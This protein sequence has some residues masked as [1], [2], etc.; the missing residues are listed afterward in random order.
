MKIADGVTVT[1]GS[2][3]RQ[4]Q[5]GVTVSFERASGGLSHPTHVDLE[6]LEVVVDPSSTDQHLL[7]TVNVPHGAISGG[8][9]LSIESAGGTINQADVIDVTPI[10]AGPSGDDSNLGTTNE[11]FRTLKQALS[12]AGPNDTCVLSAGTYDVTSG[13]TWGYTP[14]DALTLTGDSASGT[15][16]QGPAAASLTPAG[17]LTVQNLSFSGFGSALAITETAQ[18]SVNDVTID[19]GGE[20]IVLGGAGSMV[21]VSGGSIASGSYGIELGGTC[22]HCTLSITGTTLTE[23]GDG[24]ILQVSKMAQHSDLS[25]QQATLK[26]GTFVADAT[27]TLSIQDSTL[28]GNDANAALN[29]GGAT[30][31]TT[32]STFTAG[33]GPYGINLASGVMALNDAQVAG[34]QY[35]VYQLGGSSTVRNTKITNYSSIGFYFASGDL[36]LGTATQAGNNSFKAAADGAFGL[37]VDTSTSP[38]TCSNTSFDGVVPA[39]SV[40]LDSGTD[41]LEQPHEYVLTPTKTISFYNVP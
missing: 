15:V 30:L 39:T 8:R 12:V 6:D 41:L 36:D 40:V 19:G 18:V 21:M 34:N 10:S 27:A 31:D 20:G 7:L 11:P 25:L 1:P 5:T 23:S 3:V 4:G 16:L 24:P 9:A 14:P 13:E 33:T 28:T 38:L 22:D 37:Y 17:T 2:E 32:G 35:G 29:F 26:G